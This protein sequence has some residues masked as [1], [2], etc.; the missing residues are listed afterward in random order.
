[1][2]GLDAEIERFLEQGRR[3]VMDAMR[4][5]GEQ[6]VAYNIENGDYRNRTGN[7]R[8]SNFY[9]VAE[10]GLVIGNSAD[11]ASDVEARGYMVCT[12]GALLAER[13]LN[14]D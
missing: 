4:K 3:D 1:M 12:G 5:A 9:E 13:L 14:G 11:Y 6:A 10:D 7:L 2:Q 8:R